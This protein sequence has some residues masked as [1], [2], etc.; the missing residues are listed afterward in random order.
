MD[1][2]NAFR[3]GNL[4][5]DIYM[6]PPLVVLI[7]TSYVRKLKRSLNGLKQTRRAWFDKL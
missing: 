3:H 7:A 4:K 2:K 1:V 5:E 6:K